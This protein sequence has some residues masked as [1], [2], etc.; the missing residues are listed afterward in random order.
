MEIAR[1][2]GRDLG[3]MNALDGDRTDAIMLRADKIRT[4]FAFVSVAAGDYLY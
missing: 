3:A 1:A 2:A 4:I